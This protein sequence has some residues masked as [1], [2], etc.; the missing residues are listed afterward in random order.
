MTR[1]EKKMLVAFL[2]VATTIITECAVVLTGENRAKNAVFA[3]D[4]VT[5]EEITY[6]EEETV[7]YDEFSLMP[8][9]APSEFMGWYETYG[10]EY[11]SEAVEEEETEVESEQVSE[12]ST[13][14]ESVSES[15]ESSVCT[16]VETETEAPKKVW[17][18]NGEQI[19]TGIT[20]MLTE[21]LDRHGIS[22]WIE[23]AL[24]QVYQ[25]SHAQQYAVS[26]DGR[27]H[28]IL[29]YRAQFWGRQS[30]LENTLLY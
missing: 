7:D 16:E 29:Q 17:Y 10:G 20:D 26:K 1:D 4:S 23:G 5:V 14:S 15:S 9:V 28:G 27:D 18:V 2:V 25:E 8:C 13:E 30:G 22:F 3:D 19:D 24:A 12:V 6:V 21:A 11:E